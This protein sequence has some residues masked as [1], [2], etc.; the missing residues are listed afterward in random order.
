M[1]K[2]LTKR[3]ANGD[4][5]VAGFVPTF[6]F[7][8]NSPAHFAPSWGATWL[9]EDGTS[10]IGS[11]PAWADMANWQKSLVD[12]YGI[13]KLT[14]FTAGAGQEFS[15]DHA[16][17]KGKI[18]LM[19]DG[20]YRNAFIKDQ[21]P[22]ID[23]GTAPFP[24]ADDRPELY[25]GGYI[26]GNIIGIGK[27]SRNPDAAWELVK[28]LTT[29]TGAMVKLANG[30]KNV[31]ST[32]PALQSPDLVAD[33]EF[34]TFVDIFGNAHSDTTPASPN[35]GAYQNTFQDFL[36]KWQNGDVKNLEAG[37]KGVDKQIN[38][39]LKLGSAP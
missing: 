24:V 18:A 23:Y 31:P 5:Q 11:D 34:K 30:I 9:K 27:G 4:I 37:L 7:Y 14:K 21:A 1:A 25:G 26:T 12:W 32:L 20:E 22:S 3:S 28:Y 8:E 33:P 10:D 35:G 15:A 19:M 39:A 6:G 16:F 13:D 17:Q 36:I 38:A 2:K 29:D